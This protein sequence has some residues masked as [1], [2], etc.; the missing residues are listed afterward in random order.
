[1]DHDRR[2]LFIKTGDGYLE[3][4]TVQFALLYI[5][6]GWHFVESARVESGEQMVA[7]F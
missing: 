6:D 3:I 5:S 1:M 4:S 7:E 2:K